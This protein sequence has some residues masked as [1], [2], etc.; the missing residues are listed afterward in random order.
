M[1][2]VVNPKV[3]HRRPTKFLRELYMQKHCQLE[4]RG[5]ETVWKKERLLDPRTI[6]EGRKL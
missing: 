3:I 5:I 2:N 1:S 4:L 6:L